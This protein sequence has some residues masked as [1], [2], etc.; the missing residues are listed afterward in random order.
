MVRAL[1]LGEWSELM[2][3]V[4]PVEKRRLRAERRIGRIE[5]TELSNTKNAVVTRAK[6]R[7][8]WRLHGGA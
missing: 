3:S 2:G 8:H 1:T 6:R 7:E 5:I 4:D